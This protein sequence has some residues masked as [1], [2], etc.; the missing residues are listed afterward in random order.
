MK[1]LTDNLIDESGI[2]QFGHLEIAK[3]IKEIIRNDIDGDKKKSITIGIFGKWGVGKTSVINLLRFEELKEKENELVYIDIPIWKYSDSKSIRRKFIYQIAEKLN[4]KDE[5]KKLYYQITTEGSLTFIKKIKELVKELRS[6]LERLIYFMFILFIVAI[7]AFVIF[8]EIGLNNF[9]LFYNSAISIAIVGFIYK[10]IQDIKFSKTSE[11]QKVFEGEEQFEHLVEKCLS[12]SNEK[13]IFI[14]DDLDRCDS[15]KILSVFE[16][17]KNFI[18]IENCVF[19]IACDPEVIRNAID[20]ESNKKEKTSHNSQITIN[21][22]SKNSRFYLEKIFQYVVEIPGFLPQ[23]MRDYAKKILA[24]AKLDIFETG[25]IKASMDKILYTLIYRD[26]FNPRKVKTLVNRFILNY[27]VI[28]R[29]ERS[30]KT[31]LSKG[32]I[33]SFPER[34]AFF[35]VLKSDFPGIVELLKEAPSSNIK[36]WVSSI[37]NQNDFKEYFNQNNYLFSEDWNM[38]PYIYF[39]SDPSV[40]PLQ[41]MQIENIAALSSSLRNGNI[42]NIQE[43]LKAE[44]EIAEFIQ[45]SLNQV[46]ILN[47]EVEIRNAVI[48]ILSLFKELDF[49]TIKFDK[50]SISQWKF[51]QSISALLKTKNFDNEGF[52]ALVA[53]FLQNHMKQ[54]SVLL[55]EFLKDYVQ[56]NYETLEVVFSEKYF[57]VYNKNCKRLIINHI[58]PNISNINSV[59]MLFNTF[60]WST[61]T[62]DYALKQ[63]KLL[64]E[65]YSKIQD[66]EEI[67]TVEEEKIESEYFKAL[68]SCL[69]IRTSVYRDFFIPNISLNT[70]ISVFE[71][72]V[73]SMS[74]E[75]ISLLFDS[76]LNICESDNIIVIQD[77]TLDFFNTII[78]THDLPAELEKRLDDAFHS[79]IENGDIYVMGLKPITSLLSFISDCK[80]RMKLDFN[81]SIIALQGSIVYHEDAS[82][83]KSVFD[84]IMKNYNDDFEPSQII[85]SIISYVFNAPPELN[86]VT[87]VD[88]IVNEFFEFANFYINKGLEKGLEL[89]DESV[90]EITSRHTCAPRTISQYSEEFHDGIFGIMVLLQKEADIMFENLFLYV[91]INSNSYS[92]SILEYSISSLLKVMNVEDHP[93]EKESEE[94]TILKQLI[95]DTKTKLPIR[96]Q[97]FVYRFL[98]LN[99]WWPDSDIKYLEMITFYTRLIPVEIRPKFFT[100]AEIRLCRILSPKRWY[101]END[102]S[103]IVLKVC[104]CINTISKHHTFNSPELAESLCAAFNYYIQ[105][106]GYVHELIAIL[107]VLNADFV[108]ANSIP[109]RSKFAR[110]MRLALQN[111]KKVRKGI[112]SDINKKFNLRIGKRYFMY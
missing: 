102:W 2:D 20:T 48:V 101:K 45:Y 33:T 91:L 84:W 109:N 110:N 42:T 95:L 30:D 11:T 105:K 37:E 38:L 46:E 72:E 70:F 68:K 31:F 63:F 35:T 6:D 53:Y 66:G 16:V 54:G 82:I 3:E 5:I 22:P 80:N 49:Q 18:S 50:Q 51:H 78:Q 24:V 25:N 112:G 23:N 61:E 89:S 69:K 64:A 27:N 111:Y 96:F 60:S 108:P 57:E 92:V 107:K 71:D 75:A 40:A 79:E 34:L 65:L 98:K 81:R 7:V 39:N 73:P 74:N 4:Q 86:T 44:S 32:A 77:V 55:K 76:V 26:T 99:T 59:F 106:K 36:S 87:E 28:L 43:D 14:I 17:I 85:D 88:N 104:D 41:S 93:L 29:L 8:K 13:K 21:R 1:Y 62:F 56:T 9:Y 52:V 94:T 97:I 15:S 10:L 19:L 100:N 58:E 90:V 47:N 83:S 12:K 103:S 67:S